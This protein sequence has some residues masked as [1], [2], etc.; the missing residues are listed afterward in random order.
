[1]RLLL[2]LTLSM[3]CAPAFAQTGSRTPPGPP[4]PPP[5]PPSYLPFAVITE[6]FDSLPAGLSICPSGWFCVNNSTPL[7]STGWF[8]GVSGI[9]TPHAGPGYIAANFN[10]AGNGPGLDTID[11]WLMTPVLNFGVGA[12][13]SFWTRTV[14]LPAFP[15]RLEIRLSTNGASTSV[16]DFSTVLGV[17]NPNLVTTPVTCVALPNTNGYPNAWC[18]FVITSGIPTSG[19]GR[20]AFRYY[21]TD[22]GPLGNNSDYIGIDTFSF[23]E[24][25]LPTDLQLTLA[26][27]SVGPI[28]VGTPVALTATLRNAG[29]VNAAGVTGTFTIPAGLSYVSN[30]CGAT[31]ASPTLTWSVGALAAG[32]SASCTINLTAAAPG[33]HTVNGNATMTNVDTNPANNTASSQVQV[34]ANADL[35]LTI[36]GPGTGVIGSN[37]NFTATVSNAGPANATG[38]VATFT[39]PAGL[40]YVS[41]SCGA[42]FASPTL[43]WTIG[44]LA[45][46]G[47]VSCTIT[48]TL[49]A[50]SA[51]LN[52]S[53]TGNENDPTPGNNAGSAAITGIPG[54]RP[55]PSLNTIGLGI[56]VLV[57]LGIAIAGLRER[58]SV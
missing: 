55:V 16:G 39:V 40:T 41:N 57:M 11:N 50:T 1:M 7:G 45:S 21:V 43:T 18:N 5:G 52:G 3:L 13:L 35:S 23:D 12:T 38:V 29:T 33:T 20:I 22:A 37:V 9:F 51:T 8:N 15:D 17:V 56:L 49:N 32:G 30:S 4:G 27:S 34:I 58:R 36:T 2:L 46:G 54:A 10:N 26:P 14:D 53:V 44:A 19:S 31:F 28:T 6:S 47:N 42:T 25:L 48:F 24:G